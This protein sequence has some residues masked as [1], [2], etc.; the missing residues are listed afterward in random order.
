MHKK[1]LKDLFMQIK[2]FLITID[3]M[4]RVCF[5]FIFNTIRLLV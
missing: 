4:G 3:E 1:T 5:I 2:T